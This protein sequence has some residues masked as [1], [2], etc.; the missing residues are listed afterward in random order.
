MRSLTR[1]P[2][3]RMI[4][5]GVVGLIVVG[6]IVSLSGGGTSN[7][8]EQ[9]PLSTWSAPASVLSGTAATS[10]GQVFVLANSGSAANVQAINASSGKVE[11][12]FAVSNA[13]RSLAISAT[14]TL[15]VGSAT[16]NTGA[17]SFLSRLGVHHGVVAM[18]GPVLQLIPE[19]DGR[20]FLALVSAKKT[21]SAV[22]V[23]SV[24]DKVTN[25]VPLSNLSL[26]LAVSP[27]GSTIYDLLSN[28]VVQMV[29]TVSAKSFTNF[30][31]PAGGRAI[32][33]SA[34][35]STLFELKG[36]PSDDNVAVINAS[37]QT[38][39]SVMPAPANCVAIAPSLTQP[40][41]YDFVGT[42][43][44]GNVQLFAVHS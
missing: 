19:V 37:T 23:N 31:V 35:G 28:N 14:G 13:A 40:Q 24:T 20:S 33:L 8:N 4:I 41:L 22:V 5:A 30:A 43:R 44:Y 18:P 26:S 10:S 7:S 16:T 3:A 11:N 17:V 29:S 32:A 34:D 39:T 25:V 21:A 27:D 6:L 9:L 2:R 12:I 1:V 42:P 15:A 38:V 36:A